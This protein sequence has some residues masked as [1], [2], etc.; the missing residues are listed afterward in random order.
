MRFLIVPVASPS[1]RQNSSSLFT[2][3]PLIS[4]A[5]ILLCQNPEPKLFYEQLEHVSAIR[6]S[7]MRPITIFFAEFIE[8]IA[9]H[10]TLLAHQFLQKMAFASLFEILKQRA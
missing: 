5:R 9:K 1:L 6:L 7:R 2:C 8:F 4:V 10:R 3:L